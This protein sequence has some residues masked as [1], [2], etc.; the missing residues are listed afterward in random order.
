VEPTAINIDSSVSRRAPRKIR[1]PDFADASRSPVMLKLR[2][3][4][5]ATESG[6]SP[7]AKVLI[8]CGSPFS[9]TLKASRPRPVTG[10]PA[11]SVTV[12]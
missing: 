6:N 2:S 4:A 12:A 8:C 7:A 10:F 11:L 5:T 1:A 3:M 9:R